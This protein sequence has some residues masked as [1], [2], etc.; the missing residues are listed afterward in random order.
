M[1]HK[2]KNIVLV[3]VFIIVLTLCYQFAIS[4]TMALK[5]DYNSLKQEEML[6]KNTPKQLSLLVQ[7]QKYYDSLLNKYQITSLCISINYDIKGEE[8]LMLDETNY[9][10]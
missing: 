4:K 10:Y 6:L 3:V 9:L 1:T 2:S 8:P 7:K 5:K